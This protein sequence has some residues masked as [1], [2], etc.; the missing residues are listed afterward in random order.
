MGGGNKPESLGDHRQV[1][2]RV[3][4]RANHQPEAFASPSQ[5]SSHQVVWKKLNAVIIINKKP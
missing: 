4:I 1:T 2:Q 3:D 5:Y